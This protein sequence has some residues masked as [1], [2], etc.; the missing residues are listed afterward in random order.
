MIEKGDMA[1]Q[2]EISIGDYGNSMSTSALPTNS[3]TASS[4]PMFDGT[5]YYYCNW[6]DGMYLMFCSHFLFFVI[7][8]NH[9]QTNGLPFNYGDKLF[10]QRYQL[11]AQIPNR[12][13]TNIG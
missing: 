11:C 1:I 4:Q 2:F 13:P 7:Q 5:K 6:D 12:K 3:L 9:V 10:V 8:L